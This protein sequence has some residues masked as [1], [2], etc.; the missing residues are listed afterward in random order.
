MLRG[1]VGT[2]PRRHA[3]KGRRPAVPTAA[4]VAL[5]LTLG[6]ALAAPAFAQS[7]D[8]GPRYF[9][10]TGRLHWDAAVYRRGGDAG[11]GSGGAREARTLLRRARLGA[12]GGAGRFSYR[13]VVDAD[14]AGGSPARTVEI[15]DAAI[16]YS[17][18]DR[19]RLGVGRMKIPVTFEETASS[20]SM[21]FIERALPIDAFTDETLGPRVTNAQVW[22]YGRNHL[23]EAAVHLARDAGAGPDAD[24]HAKKLGV[25]GRAVFAP[26]R[27]AAAV[28]HLGGWVDRSGGPVGEARWGFGPELEVANVPALTGRR[29][30]GRIDAPVHGG[31]EAAWLDG[32]FWAQAEVVG[33]RFRRAD[34]TDYRAG[35]WYAQVGYVAG[36][37]R[38]Y[39]MREANWFPVAV[40]DAVTAGGMGTVEL[41]LR[42]STVDFGEPANPTDARPVG[43]T[44]HAGRQSNVT[45]GVNWYL[46]G[47]SRLMFNAI[48]VDLDH[49]FGRR[50]ASGAAGDRPGSTGAPVTGRFRIYGVRWQYH[51]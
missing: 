17:P 28:L 43:D 26:V 50:M 29:P 32:P 6:C 9:A 22:I 33:G 40:T 27:T 24:A 23:V 19:I 8:P 21:A 13:F 35:G 4:C 3:E 34:R 45:A 44:G 12:V 18:S 36:G 49:A 39:D 51:W 38:R 16:Y 15:E 47:R 2:A 42:Y 5:V 48:H 41:A 7:T 31:L 1:A 14:A 30:D 20:N 37:A 46:T 10:F 25:T 11:G